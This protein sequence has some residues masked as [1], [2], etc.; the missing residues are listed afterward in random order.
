VA[1]KRK[2]KINGVISGYWS[3]HL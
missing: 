2:Y 3:Y 1:G